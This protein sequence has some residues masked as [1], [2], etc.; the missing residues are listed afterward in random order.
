MIPDDDKSVAA[1][2]NAVAETAKA[3]AEAAKLGKAVV[4]VVAG[5]GAYLDRAIGTLPQDV[6]SFVG[7]AWMHEIALRNR[8]RLEMNTARKL[9]EMGVK[10]P[11]EPS[12]SIMLP[13]LEAAQMESREELQDLWATLLANAMHPDRSIR[14]RRTFFDLVQRLEPADAIVLKLNHRN[15][16]SDRSWDRMIQRNNKMKEAAEMLGVSPQEFSL[17]EDALF[18]LNLLDG[19]GDEARMTTLAVGLMAALGEA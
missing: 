15:P 16:N 6:I 7:G 17:A 1:D 12:P 11:I 3:V 2:G 4:T 13:L 8:A 9:E 14:V 19:R 5:A 18:R 10:Y